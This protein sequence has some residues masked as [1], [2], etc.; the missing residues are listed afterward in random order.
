MHSK[1]LVAQTHM[2][3]E[4]LNEAVKKDDVI[5]GMVMETG[6]LSEAWRVLVKMV[7]ET[8]DASTYQ[9]KRTWR[10]Y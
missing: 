3:W 4:A 10:P 5:L 8:N 9:V 2:I 1:Q 7:A 6:S